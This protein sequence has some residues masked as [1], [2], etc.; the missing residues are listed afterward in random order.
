MCGW[1]AAL[2]TVDVQGSVAM[3]CSRRSTSDAS[4]PSQQREVV[5][6]VEMVV[7]EGKGLTPAAGGNQ[8]R[9]RTCSANAGSSFLYA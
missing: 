9:P 1:R 3:A 8:F 4:R 2:V 7:V 6:W 5:E